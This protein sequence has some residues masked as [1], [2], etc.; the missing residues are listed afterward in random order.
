[1]RPPALDLGLES[2][3]WDFDDEFADPAAAQKNIVVAA[4]SKDELPWPSCRTPIAEDLNFTQEDI[5]QAF[6]VPPP[7][8]LL[9][10]PGYYWSARRALGRLAREV[11][12][13]ASQLE[14]EEA[15]RDGLL[16]ELARASRPRL[17]GSDR[18]VAPYDRVDRAAQVAE[19]A[20]AA[21]AGADA[22]G[23]S[24]LSQIDVELETAGATA[25][26]RTRDAAE[27]RGLAGGGERDLARLRAAV[28]RYAIERRNIVARAQE[29][30][31]PGAEMPPEL[32]GRFLAVEEQIKR[33]EADLAI[34]QAAQKQLDVQLRAA[35]DEERR[36]LA[37]IRQIEGKR[38]GLIL[39]QQGTLGDLNEALE[40]AEAAL[41]AALAEVGLG[42][43]E[44]R[45]DVPVDESVR[46][47]LLAADASIAN[48]ALTLERCRRAR[49][50]IDTSAYQEGR[51]ILIAGAV[52]SVSLLVWLLSR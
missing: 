46:K 45:G 26:L 13:L 37:H 23:E 21:L 39:S 25:A 36:A 15:V 10:A 14:A 42:I 30:S 50:S 22:R 27:R 18:F 16:G 40:R 3:V 19:D 29:T 8:G 11:A 2:T 41:V 4:P 17:Q 34:A 35:E 38:E 32:A 12:L 43:M 49:E 20:R 47:Q 24:G 44:L 5:A 9:S 48:C 7:S 6:G 51:A 31:T 28:Q 52:L 1:V 33:G